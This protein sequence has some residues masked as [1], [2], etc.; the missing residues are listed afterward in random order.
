MKSID[1]LKRLTGEDAAPKT[2]DQPEAVPLSSERQS[3]LADLRR[4][5]D[6]VVT[7]TAARSKAAQEE[8]RS[9]GNRGLSEILEGCE[10]ENDHGRFFLVPNVGQV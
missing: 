1:K 3:Q 2:K 5:I 6:S 4:R 9:R 10:I 7:R 8:A